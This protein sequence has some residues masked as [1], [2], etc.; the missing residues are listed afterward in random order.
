MATASISLVREF[1]SVVRPPRALWVPFPFGRPLGAPGDPAIQR[2]VLL[3]LLTLLESPG[4]PVLE[5]F[6]L[7]DE[8][9]HL[10][11][12]NQTLG[13]KCGPKGC[14]LDSML[15]HSANGAQD[16]PRAGP[17]RPPYDGN[18]EKIRTE[19][20]SLRA[21]HGRYIEGS[22][23]RTQIGS[24]GIAPQAIM[25]AAEVVH[26]FALGKPIEIPGRSG[27]PMTPALFVR[28]SIDDLKAYYIEAWAHLNGG[29]AS[30]AADA[31]D[32]LW[33][34]TLMSGLIIA[35]RDRIIETTDRDKDPNWVL[36]RSIVPRGYGAS[37]YTMTHV[38]DGKARV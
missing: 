36:A 34:E 12:R 13:R 32:W 15:S 7:T 20:E 21:A 3:A 19:I 5:E 2:R 28:L 10:D 29:E 9:R 25:V 37:G 35:A 16:A 4:G 30:D 38:T 17:A 22:G 8:E 26:R 33:K 18:F 14:S 1:T 11:A 31:N 6:R 27:R 24:S 23:G